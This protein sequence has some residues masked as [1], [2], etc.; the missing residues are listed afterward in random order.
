MIQNKFH[1]AITGKTDAEIIYNKADCSK[2]H[3][4][5]TT[6]KNSPNGRIL[7]SDTEIAKNYLSE[8]EIKRLERTV[9]GF[10]DYIEDLIERNNT[11]TMEQFSL[12][13]DSFLSFR[14]YKILANKGTVSRQH[15]LSKAHSEYDKFNKTQKIDSDFDHFIKSLPISNKKTN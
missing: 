14:Q 6:W 2:E 9:T 8:K 12:S 4:G 3:M 13:V 11:F 5:L 1:Y 7:K 10:F 15:A